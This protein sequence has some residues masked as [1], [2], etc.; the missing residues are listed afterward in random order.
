[1]TENNAS[2]EQETK[3][4][5]QTF[6]AINRLNPAFVVITGDLINRSDGGDG[7]LKQID[8]FKR[9]LSLLNKSIPVYYIPGNHDVS[10]DT[11]LQNFYLSHFGYDR[12]SAL[13]NNTRL[14]GI[15]SQL[16]W[17]KRETLENEQYQWLEN[18]LK[19]SQKNNHRFI[20]SHHPLF[21][22]DID[23]GDTYQNLPTQYRSKYLDLFDKYNVHYKF[24]GHL[25]R[26]HILQVENLTIIAT[27]AICVS[28]SSEPPG[29]RIVKVYPD[30][31]VHNY[32]SLDTLPTQ[33][34]L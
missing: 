29:L 28:H 3:I 22:Q 5:T 31:V 30:K 18:E 17:A 9:L 11:E 21:L 23:E 14:L 1:M 8:E 19:K 33:I 2:F 16:I 6:S 24:S 32:Y 27:N 4:I 20:F 10:A 34:K 25:H 13:H 7:S 15:N 26:N 12:F